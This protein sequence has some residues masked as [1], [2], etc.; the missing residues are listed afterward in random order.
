MLF[1]STTCAASKE[2]TGHSIFPSVGFYS[3]NPSA[4]EKIPNQ[5][6]RL[7]LISPNLP[8]KNNTVDKITCFG[9]SGASQRESET[10]LQLC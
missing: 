2:Q 9:V 3:V 6:T 4:G 5:Q 10:S 8:M 1:L 7:D